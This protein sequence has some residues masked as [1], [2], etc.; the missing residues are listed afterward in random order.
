MPDEK[1]KSCPECDGLG[2][3]Q[4]E[5]HVDHTGW[6]IATTCR[7]CKGDG[8]NRLLI[9]EVWEYRRRVF[10]ADD[11]AKERWNRRIEKDTSDE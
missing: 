4:Y 11:V 9:D 7:L 6:P 2:V 3:T 10:S 8:W 1:M 5:D